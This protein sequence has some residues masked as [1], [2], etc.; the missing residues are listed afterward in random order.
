M[1]GFW[2][3]SLIHA[4]GCRGTLGVRKTMSMLSEAD[5]NK[6]VTEQQ[7]GHLKLTTRATVGVLCVAATCLFA[8]DSAILCCKGIAALPAGQEYDA[9]R[10]REFSPAWP[11]L[12]EPACSRAS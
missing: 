7:N 8:L 6:R 3:I 5:L 9:H 12:D 1:D 2:G 10:H 4:L 11:A